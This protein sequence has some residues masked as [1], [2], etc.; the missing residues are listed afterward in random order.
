MKVKDIIDGLN[1][2]PEDYDIVLSK[3]VTFDKKEELIAVEDIPIRGLAVSDDSKEV[4]FI[5]NDS[6]IDAI[7]GVETKFWL[8]EKELNVISK[9]LL[10]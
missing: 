9:N 1:E 10:T 6:D 5:L 8:F 4:R 3:Y 2:L 7:K